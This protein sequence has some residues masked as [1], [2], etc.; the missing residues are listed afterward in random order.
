LAPAQ[1]G[2]YAAA[3]SLS[4][5]VRLFGSTFTLVALPALAP[6]HDHERSANDLGGLSRATVYTSLLAG[7]AVVVLAPA[8]LVCCSGQRSRR[9]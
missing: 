4:T 9:R 3:L 2:L 8:P 5:I 1:L 7:V 6:S